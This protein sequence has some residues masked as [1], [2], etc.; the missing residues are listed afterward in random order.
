MP[1][2]YKKPSL[3]VLARHLLSIFSDYFLMVSHDVIVRFAPKIQNSPVFGSSPRKVHFFYCTC[4]NDFKYLILS[5]KSL[6]LLR[7][8][9]IGNIYIYV[10]KKNPFTFNQVKELKGSFPFSMEIKMTRRPLSWGGV[11]LLLV[12]LA[13]F[14][15][16]NL[17]IAADDYIFKVD[18]DVLFIS[19]RIFKKV[20]AENHEAFGQAKPKPDDFMEGGSYFLK[21]TLVTRIVRSPIRKAIIYASSSWGCSIDQAPED[22]AISK[23]AQ[24]NG[25]KLMLCEYRL[26]GRDMWRLI[27]NEAIKSY[28]IIHCSPHAGVKKE[29]MIDIWKLLA[30]RKRMQAD[31]GIKRS[32]S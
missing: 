2:L 15:E 14:E 11:K 29:T 8:D 24:E 3:V 1:R 32:L 16:I 12:E 31:S 6:E 30:L 5:L 21:S 20:I 25:V 17:N 13:A 23:L 26:G 9:C 7:L 27:K 19:D 10:D 22:R 4:G 18:S 28:S